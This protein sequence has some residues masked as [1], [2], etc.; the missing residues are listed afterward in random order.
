[1][2]A[3]HKNH[4]K[5]F[6]QV[7]RRIRYF[8]CLGKKAAMGGID[9]SVHFHRRAFLN[10]CL[11][12]FYKATPQGLIATVSNA[13][14]LRYLSIAMCSACLGPLFVTGK[15]RRVSINFLQQYFFGLPASIV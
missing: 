14:T 4:C 11:V 6:N 12:A 15:V 3:L 9:V 13:R 8:Y 5:P 10:N 7:N 2:G 1:M